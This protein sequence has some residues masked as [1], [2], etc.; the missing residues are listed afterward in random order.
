MK[1]KSIVQNAILNGIKTMVT[2]AFPIITF[3]YS[4][5]VLLPDGVGKINFAK[6]FVAYFTFLSMLGVVNYGT[7]E[8]SKIKQNK[9]AL[10]RFAHEILIINS[11]STLLS[12]V[13]FCVIIQNSAFSQYRILLWINSITIFLTPLGMD[14]LYN[15]LE[16][17]EYITI[18]TCVVQGI[19]LLSIFLFVRSQEDIYIYALIQTL[20]ATG[21]NVVNLVHSRKL[22][23]YRNVGNYN[24]KQH[25]K[26]ITIIF[27]MTLFIQVFTHLDT[28]MVGLLAGDTATGLYSAANKMISMVA[29]L[30]T[31]IVMVFMPRL[32][33]NSGKQ[34]VNEIKKLS[35][36][37]LNIV[38]MVGMPAMVGIFLL[39]TPI[40]EIFSGAGFKAAILT[41]KV[42]SGRILL[43]P[44]NT[45]ITIYLFI[46][47]N[48]EKWNL[49]STGIAALMNFVMNCLLISHWQQNG[50]ALATVMAEIVELCIN[51]ILLG[52]V[53]N[54]E[55]V[56]KYLW[57]YITG[58]LFIVAMY[59]LL[60]CVISNGYVVML[61]TAVLC[62][63]MYFLYLYFLKNP[64]VMLF[65]NYIGKNV[66]LKH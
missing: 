25:I 42:L 26:P 37:A 43:V 8:A 56:V 4:S 47:I 64:Y 30:I 54:L 46:P 66:R 58:C 60:I 59:L 33:T 5:R 57:Q 38:L 3:M 36:E 45:F 29:A 1:Q 12:F 44:M 11:I 39:S 55:Q 20:A 27:G 10:T 41:S 15:A 40:I 23:I 28:T 34:D 14:W 9:V 6:S 16:E 48:K 63:M 35:Y 52:K 65:L 21:S 2:M 18:R 53:M 51:L 50:A 19:G 62:S 7:K 61:A 31:S 32:A 49:V 13:L 17:F 24:L 22:L